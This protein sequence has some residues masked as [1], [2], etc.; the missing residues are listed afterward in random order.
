MKPAARAIKAAEARR[1]EAMKTKRSN[2]L[3]CFMIQSIERGG[4]GRLGN[5][6]D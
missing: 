1:K 5:V 4:I 2:M 6:R 3:T